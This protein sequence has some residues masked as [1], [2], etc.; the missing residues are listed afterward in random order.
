MKRQYVVPGI[1]IERYAMTQSASGC[2]TK[3]GAWD[4]DCV[5]KD[6]DATDRMKDFAVQG[7]FTEG[8][9]CKLPGSIFDG[10]DL[11]TI[12]YHTSVQ[13]AFAS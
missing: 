8:S 9:G 4:Q 5:L 12:C 6:A 10:W 2:I 1:T 3:I 13:S 7:Y 11:D